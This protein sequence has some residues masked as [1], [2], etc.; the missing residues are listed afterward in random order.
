[1]CQPRQVQLAHEHTEQTQMTC[2]LPKEQKVSTMKVPKLQIQKLPWNQSCRPRTKRVAVQAHIPRRMRIVPDLQKIRMHNINKQQNFV[3]FSLSV[4]S[5]SSRIFCA[6]TLMFTRN[7]Q[8]I[9][10]PN[11]TNC[12]ITM[13]TH[14]HQKWITCEQEHHRF[15]SLR[16]H[17]PNKYF[18]FIIICD[19]QSSYNVKDDI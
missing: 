3:P 2:G 18:L 17:L 12:K 16:Q 9:D 15:P 7:M 10:A 4:Q 5:K 14:M 8:L 19:V 6:H 1:M 11:S 13:K